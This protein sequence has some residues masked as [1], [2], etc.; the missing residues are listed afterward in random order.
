V[1]IARRATL[2]GVAVFAAC[3]DVSLSYGMKAVGAVS[4]ANWTEAFRAIFTPWVAVGILLLSAFFAAYLAALSFADLTYV[5]PATSLGYV[6]MAVLARFLLNEQIPL[7]RWIGIGL[8]VAGVGFVTG[9]PS[10]SSTQ[11][12]KQEDHLATSGRS[13]AGDD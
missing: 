5:L 12:E 3:G 4:L 9:G 11:K 6:L 8:I 10:S 13:V 7:N 2:A 1:T